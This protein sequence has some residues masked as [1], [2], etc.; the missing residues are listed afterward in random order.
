MQ[1]FSKPLHAFFSLIVSLLR[2]FWVLTAMKNGDKMMV[3]N[4]TPLQLVAYLN[5]TKRRNIVGTMPPAEL[6]KLWTLNEIPVETT[7]GHVLQNLVKLHSDLKV[8]NLTLYQL[9]ADVDRLIAHTVL[10]PTSNAKK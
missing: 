5:S 6:L 2:I 8:H 7:L 9:R 1:L 3:S 4:S 10:Q